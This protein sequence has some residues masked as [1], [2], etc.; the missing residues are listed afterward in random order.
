MFFINIIIRSIS[1][2]IILVYN[3]DFFHKSKGESLKLQKYKQS[4]KVILQYYFR[5]LSFLKNNL[6]VVNKFYDTKY[7]CSLHIIFMQWL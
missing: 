6:H 4:Y 5:K 2:I 7:L 3:I 1:F